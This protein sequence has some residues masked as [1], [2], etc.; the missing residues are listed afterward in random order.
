MTLRARFGVVTAAAVAFAVIAIAAFSW[1]ATRQRIYDEIDRTLVARAERATDALLGRGGTSRDGVAANLFDDPFGETFVQVVRADGVVVV[2]ADEVVVSVT[3]DD[4]AV[5]AGE[6]SAYFRSTSAEGVHV[7]VL[8]RPV[9]DGRALLVARPLDEVDATMRGLGLLLVVAA[10]VGAAGAGAVGFVTAR[11]ALQPVERVTG[12]AERIARS[13]ELGERIEAERDDE[14]GRLA[15][16]FNAMVGAL[17]L[18][19]E[20]QRQLVADASHE[21]RTPLTSLRT[22]IE[23][24]ARAEH[25]PPEQRRE[26]LSD[27]IAELEELTHL[28]AELVDLA[29]DPRAVEHDPEP[30]VL[31]EI[32][33]RIV[34]RARRRSGLDIRLVSDDSIVMARVAL[35]ERAVANLVDNACKWS[36]RDQPIDV[37]VHGGCITVRDRGPGI[38]PEQRDR[39]FDR[40][41]R[42][43]G[44]QQVPGSGLGLA[45][46][47]QIVELHDGEVFVDGAHDGGTRIGFRLP[48]EAAGFSAI[49]RNPL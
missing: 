38:A 33:E 6:R 32:V 41:Y 3:E 45:I 19:R 2:E 40:F 30:A 42:A 5:A 34:E 11:R 18:S 20:Q 4:L 15:R 28:V 9:G 36:P 47:R 14:T 16:A 29:T 31:S 22:N 8:I 26:L 23:L 35:I 10:G 7:R 39:I 46:V 37:D 1:F 17:A 43:P 13:H 49:S 27:A 21:L 24:L 12:A 25:L 44:A 48:V